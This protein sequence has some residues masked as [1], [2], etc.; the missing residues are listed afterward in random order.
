MYS[1]QASVSHPRS[2]QPNFQ[3]PKG[4]TTLISPCQRRKI[5]ACAHAESFE[6]Y[7]ILHKIHP[8]P[9]QHL[10]TQPL[11][12]FVYDHIRVVERPQQ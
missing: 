5:Q 2:P 7:I 6:G 9:F 11:V 12:T 8:R 1:K 4:S 10:N 3:E